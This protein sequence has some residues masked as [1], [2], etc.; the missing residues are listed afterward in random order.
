M[1]LSSIVRGSIQSPATV[2]GFCFSGDTPFALITIVMQCTVWPLKWQKKK[3]EFSI[4]RV[5]YISKLH[6]E[7]FLS[8]YLNY[9]IDEQ[10]KTGMHSVLGIILH[11]IFI[12]TFIITRQV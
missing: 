6:T 5:T 7:H 3:K 9:Y 10:N 2:N 8:S 1:A 11:P 12:P 4:T